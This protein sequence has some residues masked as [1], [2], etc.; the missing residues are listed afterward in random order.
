V[1]E[2][3]EPEVFRYLMERNRGVLQSGASPERE[4]EFRGR[5]FLGRIY[6]IDADTVA[7]ASTDITDRRN[8][9]DAS[10]ARLEE[11]N[12]LLE[13]LPVGVW[14][15]NADCSVITGN[16]A[17]Y[18]IMGLPQGINASVT[19]GAR[20]APL[21]LRIFVDGTEVAP[22]EAPMQRVA[23]S[24]K[25]LLNFEHEIV[26]GDGERKVVYGSAI[27]VLDEGGAV[28]KVIA[29]Y[30]DF[31][32][33]KEAEKRLRE[34][35]HRKDEFLAMLS[36]ELRNPLGAITNAIA[37]LQRLGPADP[38]LKSARDIIDRQA[39]H[40]VRVVEDLL[41]LSRVTGGKL[42][43]KVRRT[44][45]DEAATFAVEMMQPLLTERAQTVVVESPKTPLVLEAD[46]S[47]LVQVIGNVLH[48]A[49]KYSPNGARIRVSLGQDGSDAV[50]RVRDEGLGIPAEL[51]PKVFD[52]FVQ[53]QWALDPSY[54]RS[55][56]GLGLGLTLVRSIVELHGGS[57]EAASGGRG[58]GS[59]FTIR[60]P[61]LAAAA[62]SPAAPLEAAG[63]ALP[64]PKRILVV[65]DSVDSVRGMA[66]LLGISGHDI[67]TCHDG[68]SALASAADFQPDV[69]LLDLG[70]PGIDGYEVARRIRAAGNFDGAR[71]Y[72]LTGYG[73]A[74]DRRKTRE[75]GFDRHLVKPIRP[76]ELLELIEGDVL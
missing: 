5:R 3:L 17:A 15:G 2:I 67:R 39:M 31:S 23:R 69:I 59:E 37:V 28:R 13:I 41:D 72:A 46:P 44:L 53:G 20:E 70:L 62:E 22:E 36:H 50:L 48:N 60:L 43:L 11:M 8:A 19:S 52:P 71:L 27:P 29:T 68:E 40:L 38:T 16:R 76:D 54:D 47:R 66:M 12:K 4:N 45:L 30:S 10:A 14:I 63:P 34:G 26:F 32:A 65:D 74:E 25:P 49:S 56:R 35:S 73:Q 75:A 64:R 42:S 61:L 24:G 9:E 57:V 21:D 51:L 7:T 6:H 1:S 33:R 18:E 55:R 58:Q